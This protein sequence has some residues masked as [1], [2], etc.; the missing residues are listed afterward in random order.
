M[1]ADTCGSK[2]TQSGITVGKGI[3]VL[4]HTAN[5][6]R[7]VYVVYL[8]A[9]VGDLRQM[10]AERLVYPLRDGNYTVALQ[11]IVQIEL[12]VARRVAVVEMQPR[13]LLFCLYL[14]A[15][16]EHGSVAPVCRADIVLLIELRHVPHHAAPQL[17]SRS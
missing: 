1:V 2:Y 11:E 17:G 13:Y 15:H 16:I 7:I 10:R 8:D 6:G 3:A 4:R 12:V 5:G 14:V 9:A